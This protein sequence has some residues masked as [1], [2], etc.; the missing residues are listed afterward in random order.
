MTKQRKLI[1]AGMLVF[2]LAVCFAASSGIALAQSQ[3]ATSVLDTVGTSLLDQAIDFLTFIVT[4][5]FGYIL[6]GGVIV[7]LVY[8]AK[9][10]AH[11]GTRA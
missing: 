3:T 10:L 11:A 9:R 7:F 5:Y 6:L 4:K 2:A 8:L 1:V